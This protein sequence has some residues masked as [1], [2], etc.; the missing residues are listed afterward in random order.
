MPTKKKRL[1]ITLP[2][3]THVYLQRLALRDHM[4]EA[5]KAAQLLQVALEI[6]EDAFFAAVADKRAKKRK[7]LSHDAFWSKAL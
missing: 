4:P 1:N 5:T 7:L 3:E 2:E 6:E